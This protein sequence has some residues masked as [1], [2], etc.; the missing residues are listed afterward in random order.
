M[1]CPPPQP[2]HRLPKRAGNAPAAAEAQIAPLPPSARQPA[3][4]GVENSA[5]KGAFEPLGAPACPIAAEE[6]GGQ[7]LC[8]SHSPPQEHPQTA[9]CAFRSDPSPRMQPSPG[10]GVSS[11]QT[12]PHPPRPCA[13]EQRGVG[14]YQRQTWAFFALGMVFPFVFPHPKARACRRGM[15][16]VGAVGFIAPEIELGAAFGCRRHLSEVMWML[17]K[18]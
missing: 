11:H 4:A 2:S 15:Q 13:R 8:C 16:P 17:C 18:T 5:E 6:S 10:E 12:S 9:P 1:S 14:F 7:R 3:A